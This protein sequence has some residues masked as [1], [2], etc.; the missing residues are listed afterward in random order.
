MVDILGI[1][2]GDVPVEPQLG[3]GASAEVRRMMSVLEVEALL[4]SPLASGAGGVRIVGS[5]GD[6]LLD[7]EAL[8]DE[9]LARYTEVAALHGA[10]SEAL[11]EAAR[12][13]LQYAG[14]YN[15]YAE[16]LGGQ[17][18]LLAAWQALLTVAF[19]RRFEL[20]A[21]VMGSGRQPTDLV[22]WSAG[23][24]GI[25]A[26]AGYTPSALYAQRPHWR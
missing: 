16:Q 20:V 13:T 1:A 23:P 7:V 10:P 25:F 12:A 5:R 19:T 11:R 18:A 15:A 24:R 6:V 9:L 8:K 3:A 2:V 26:S 17:A 22:R 4:S 21:E 14:E